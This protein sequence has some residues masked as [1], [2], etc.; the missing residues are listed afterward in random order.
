[1]WKIG[2]SFELEINVLQPSYEFQINSTLRNIRVGCY[3]V[4]RDMLTWLFK[5]FYPFTSLSFLLLLCLSV[6]KAK[7]K[8]FAYVCSLHPVCPMILSWAVFKTG[9]SLKLIAPVFLTSSLPLWILWECLFIFTHNA[10]WLA[11]SFRTHVY[12]QYLKMHSLCT[13][14]EIEVLSHFIY[15]SP[16]YQIDPCF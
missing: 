5:L 13:V 10:M 8:I 4:G 3:S 2:R 12:A 7:R 15:W 16:G 11:S 1:M 14:A 6:V 9:R